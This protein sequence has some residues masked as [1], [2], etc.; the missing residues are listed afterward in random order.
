MH[1]RDGID[2]IA[3]LFMPS[4]EYG[5]NRFR[6]GVPEYVLKGHFVA[7]VEPPVCATCGDCWDKCQFGAI[8][9]SATSD[10][11]DIDTT[12]CMGCGLCAGACSSGA[13][14]MVPREEIPIAKDLW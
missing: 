13:I 12:L 9:Y 2:F 6:S 8:H 10:T 4:T 5:M 14:E 1:Q 3:I 7:R 11:V